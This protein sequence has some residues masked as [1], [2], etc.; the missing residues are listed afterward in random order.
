MK[1]WKVLTTARECRNSGAMSHLR[2]LLEARYRGPD[3]FMDV[4]TNTEDA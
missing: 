1:R 2:S 3:A 4:R